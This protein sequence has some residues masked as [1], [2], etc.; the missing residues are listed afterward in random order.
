[1]NFSYKKPLGRVNSAVIYGLAALGVALLGLTAWQARTPEPTSTPSKSME[2]CT[3]PVPQ[4][5]STK[6]QPS[7]LPDTPEK[8]SA[9][10]STDGMVFIPA[11]KFRM[12]SKQGKPD[13]LPV[14]EVELGGFWIDKTE[15][16]NA[17]FEAFV[18][19][20][21]YVT[22]AEHTPDP[23]DFPGVPK[24]KLVAGSAIFVPPPGAVDLNEFLSWWKYEAGA[25]WRHPEGKDSSI[26]GRETHPVVHV[27]WFDAQ[28]YAKWA[29]KRLPTEAEWE[30]AARGGLDQKPYAWGDDAPNANGKWRANIWEGN[31][32]RENTKAD[33]YERTAPVGSFAPNGYGLFDM[34]G[35]VWEWCA[36]FYRPDYYAKSELKNPQGPQDSFD[37]EEPGIEKRVQRGGS[38]LCSDSYCVGYKPGT[39]MKCSP[40]TSLCHTGFR[41]VRNK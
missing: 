4:K 15:V 21:G 26:K 22:T 6:I 18:S 35:N 34:S 8:K 23:K 2:C 10:E 30:Y 37:P 9:G 38:Y 5:F 40:D 1:M 24:E 19:A 3:D 7:S 17:Q 28:A 29:G 16:T 20:T 32:P 25:N 36:D 41:C 31:F 14:H 39:R 27:S 13:E 12:G 33:G 11:G